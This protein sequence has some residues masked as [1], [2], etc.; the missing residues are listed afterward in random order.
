MSSRGDPNTRQGSGAALAGP[1]CK[2]GCERSKSSRRLGRGA[3]NGYE[4]GKVSFT[5]PMRRTPVGLSP[6]KRVGSS[7]RMLNVTTT[8][9]S[10]SDLGS[11]S[12][13]KTC[14]RTGR[15]RIQPIV[16]CIL[17]L[18]I[19]NRGPL[20]DSR[21]RRNLPRG[22][23]VNPI[24]CQMGSVGIGSGSERPLFFEKP[25]A[26]FAK[27]SRVGRGRFALC[28]RVYPWRVLISGKPGAVQ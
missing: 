10:F 19:A 18:D 17:W 25:N 27:F 6:A 5:G 12:I 13:C 16:P 24:I 22:R 8:G 9:V 4:T 11:M 7:D 20:P 15:S 14:Q 1:G 23:M 3:N 26:A 2:W 21:L 28:H